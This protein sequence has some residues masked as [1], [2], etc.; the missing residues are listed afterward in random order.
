MFDKLLDNEKL[1]GF[2]EKLRSFSVKT[3]VWKF[4]KFSATQILREIKLRWFETLKNVI[5]GNFKGCE[6]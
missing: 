4:N 3:T 2:H 5:F 6:I 1:N